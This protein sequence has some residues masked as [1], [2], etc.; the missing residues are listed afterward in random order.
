MWFFIPIPRVRRRRYRRC[1]RPTPEDQAVYSYIA[2]AVAALVLVFL[3]LRIA[4]VDVDHMPRP[5]TAVLLV[6]ALILPGAVQLAWKLYKRRTRRSA[7]PPNRQA[8]K[9]RPYPWRVGY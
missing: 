7:P 8:P 5:V 1:S 3:P 6:V 2:M 9:D 4:G